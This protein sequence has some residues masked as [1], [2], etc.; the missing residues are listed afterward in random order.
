MK[1]KIRNRYLFCPKC[2]HKWMENVDVN[3]LIITKCKK[4]GCD[5]RYSIG[6]I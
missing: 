4:C 5:I 1:P 3:H 2:F 6:E